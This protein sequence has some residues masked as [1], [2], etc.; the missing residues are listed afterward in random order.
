MF[1]HYYVEFYCSNCGNRVDRLFPPRTQ[2]IQC[3]KCKAALSCP[4]NAIKTF[5][6]RFLLFLLVA[7]IYLFVGLSLFTTFF[8]LFWFLLSPIP[9]FLCLGP[10][11]DSLSDSIATSIENG[12]GPPGVFRWLMS[13]VLYALSLG[14]VCV[15]LSWSLGPNNPF[16]ISFELNPYRVVNEP[17]GPVVA[18]SDIASSKKRLRH[19]E[20]TRPLTISP[21]GKAVLTG[22]KETVF[23]WDAQAGRLLYQFEIESDQFPSSAA[24]S[25]DGT[26]FTIGTGRGPLRCDKFAIETRPQLNSISPFSVLALMYSADGGHIC[27][28]G[29][30]HTRIYDLAGDDDATFPEG[31]TKWANRMTC[32]AHHPTERIIATGRPNQVKIYRLTSDWKTVSLPHDHL[33]VTSVLFHTN[34][35][36]LVTTATAVENADSKGDF[37][38]LWNLKTDTRIR[39]FAGHAGGVTTAAIH[40]DGQTLLSGGVD[41]TLR[42]WDLNTGKQLRT[43]D[44]GMPL[45][46][47]AISPDGTNVYAL[48]QTEYM[49]TRESFYWEIPFSLSQ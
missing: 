41:R 1:K 47:L 18:M 36:H 11:A 44:T 23:L 38:Q 39:T 33:N 42:F 27:A 45:V 21:N 49:D 20:N 13:I 8:G 46:T 37:I 24:F 26:E 14:V 29:L 40:P 6:K 9:L 28:A 19:E 31:R 22:N 7:P 48:T 35:E 5:W 17:A 15:G 3:G 30:E 4:Y 32:I 25:S 2:M 12:Q 34:G 16:G 10:V 43:I